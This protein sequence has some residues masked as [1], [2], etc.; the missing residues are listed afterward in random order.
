MVAYPYV[1]FAV[2]LIIVVIG[3]LL[4]GVSGASVSRQPPISGRMKDA[5]IAK[6][7]RQQQRIP[8][9]V[10]MIG[11]GLICVAASLLWRFAGLLR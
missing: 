1:L 7:L 8:F 5:E 2:G 10:L 4:A 9:P 3:S 6:H 11:F